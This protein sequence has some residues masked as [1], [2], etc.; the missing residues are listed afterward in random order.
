MYFHSRRHKLQQQTILKQCYGD[1]TKSTLFAKKCFHFTAYLC[2]RKSSLAKFCQTHPAKHRSV[3]FKC[4]KTR[5]ATS[6]GSCLR[7]GNDLG[8]NLSLLSL[9][10]PLR[11]STSPSSSFILLSIWP[12]LTHWFLFITCHQCSA[13]NFSERGT[14][15]S[16]SI[17][18]NNNKTTTNTAINI[19]TSFRISK[20]LIKL[21]LYFILVHIPCLPYSYFL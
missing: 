16:D 5:R 18:Y 8:C 10:R 1:H 17:Y 2:Q 12:I 20:H 13:V 4:D 15:S 7:S 9:R 19:S 3:A 14:H 21:I 11:S 6:G